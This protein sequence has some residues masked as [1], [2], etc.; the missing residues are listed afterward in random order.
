MLDCNARAC[1]AVHG[2]DAA[3]PRPAQ[4]GHPTA[5]LSLQQ[6]LQKEFDTA[7][8]SRTEEA[9][10]RRWLI[11]TGP[12]NAAKLHREASGG[13]RERP[14]WTWTCGCGWAFG[15]FANYEFWT[16]AE[17]KEWKGERCDRCDLAG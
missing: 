17:A 4:P 1:Q 13:A 5:S 7:Q 3:D 15:T 6:E 11:S 8:K 9:K 14:S 10:R 16:P 12:S 2:H